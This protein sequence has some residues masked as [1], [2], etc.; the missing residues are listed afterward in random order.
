M[1]M[2]LYVYAKDHSC[3]RYTDKK[4]FGK[5]KVKINRKQL[6]IILVKKSGIQLVNISEKSQF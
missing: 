6:S 2:S 4:N 1:C 5:A 3:E